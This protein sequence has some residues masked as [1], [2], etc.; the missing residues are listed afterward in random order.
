VRTDDILLGEVLRR[1]FTDLQLL[2]SSLGGHTFVS[3]GL[4]W[5]CALFGRDS[6]VASL[7]LLPYD[8]QLAAS[9]LRLLATYQGDRVDEW[10]DEEP[11]RIL[12][13]LRVGEMARSGEIPHS[14]YYGTID[15]TALFLL[16]LARQASWTGDLGLFTELRANVD[17]ALEWIATYG[18][19]DG[20]GY[21][22]Y[23][24]SS[25]HG[26]VNQGWKDSGDAIVEESGAIAEP[27]IAL[28]EAQA[29]LYAAKTELAGL[30]ERTG[31]QA[32]AESL[33]REAAELRVRF[34]RDYW[35]DDL[36]CYALALESAKRAL[37]VVTSNAGHALWAG[38]ADGDKARR[39]GERLMADDMFSGW[40]VRTLASSACAYNPV[41]YHLGTVWPHDNAIVA[42]GLRR[43]GLD[44]AARRIFDGMVESAM[45]FEHARL[46]ELFAGFAR[47]EG[48][49][50]IRYP[51]ACHPQAWAAGSVPF[52]LS[53]LLGLQPDG[54]ARRLRVV[55]PVLPSSVDF[56]ELTGIGVAGAAA[57][58]RFERR[59]D[60]VMVRT[61]AVRGG[62]EVVVE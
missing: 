57:D 4:P 52:L 22:E 31:E 34:N 39:T 13:E 7:Q 47:T 28:V 26:L 30:F 3:A 38:I 35:L 55:R 40:G 21:L 54:F 25:E 42:A 6:L 17:R 15:A 53:E 29:Y 23:R 27:P 19:G 16:V 10:R 48:G 49:G 8:P 45:E 2:R 44:D 1:S 18:D 32:R 56:I 46:P 58:L 20:D 14:P 33:R 62:L 59:G 9:T 36:S 43:Y 24:S 60:D 61:L 50:P 5:F 41:G 51:V 37:R 11:G 12:H